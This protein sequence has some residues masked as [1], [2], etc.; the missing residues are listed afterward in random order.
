MGF[1]A[2]LNFSIGQAGSA[3]FPFVFGVMAE[4]VSILGTSFWIR[5]SLYANPFPAL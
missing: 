4:K 3:A 1:N 2:W 5:A